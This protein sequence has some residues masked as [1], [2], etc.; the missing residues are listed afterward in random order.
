NT[1]SSTLSSLAAS[2]STQ[3]NPNLNSNASSSAGSANVSKDLSREDLLKQLLQ[4]ISASPVLAQLVSM[5]QQKSVLADLV[6]LSGGSNVKQEQQQQP[7]SFN[8]T[9]GNGSASSMMMGAMGNGKGDGPEASTTGSVDSLYATPVESQGSQQ[10][11]HQQSLK[12][13]K[14]DADAKMED[15]HAAAL[16]LLSQLAEN[17][18]MTLSDSGTPPQFAGT[19]ILSS[20]HVH[21]HETSD[22]VTS[23]KQ[24]QQQQQHHDAATA[25]MSQYARESSSTLS[26]PTTA[27]I[28]PKF[29][30]QQLNTAATASIQDSK[31]QSLS[32]PT[33]SQA[34]VQAAQAHAHAQAQ[35]AAAEQQRQLVFKLEMEESSLRRLESEYAEERK[36]MVSLE[37]SWMDKEG[38]YQNLGK[39]VAEME[40]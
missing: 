18:E 37:T 4:T 39:Q 6:K 15:E 14:E 12:Q 23:L 8:A 20:K 11:Q 21:N 25:F 10:D 5:D 34:D 32:S 38:M 22:M 28:N 16:L 7:A 24:Q 3:L 13:L 19:P 35:A 9:V 17:P 33:K 26:L 27:I 1:A 31:S 40:K 2:L 30:S 36:E 29:L